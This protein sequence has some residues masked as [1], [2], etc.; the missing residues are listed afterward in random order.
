MGSERSLKVRV[1]SIWQYILLVPILNC[2]GVKFGFGLRFELVIRDKQRGRFQR[3]GTDIWGEIFGII[4]TRLAV[5]GILLFLDRFIRRD[6][7]GRG[8]E[9]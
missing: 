9:N 6:I 2:M 5:R 8:G 4:W 3:F 7:F 1:R